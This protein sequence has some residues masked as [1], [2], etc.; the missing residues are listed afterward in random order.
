M[1][2]FLKDGKVRRTLTRTVKESTYLRY[3]R[4]LQP[5]SRLWS[6]ETGTL[7]DFLIVGA[8][9]SGSTFLHDC[10]AAAT[11]A[12]PSPLQKEVHYFD[13]KYYRSLDW[14]ARFFEDVGQKGPEVQTYEASPYYL[15]NP[16]VP[17]RVDA[18]LPDVKILAVLREPVERAVSHY[19][20]MRQVELETREAEDAFRADA[21]RA[22]LERDERYLRNFEDPLYFDFDHIHYGYIRRSMYHTQIERWRAHF[23]PSD[24]RIL[25]SEDLFEDT[26]A[27][28][29]SVA[30]F[31]GLEYTGLEDTNQTNT[32]E[33]RDEIEVGEAAYDIAERALTDVEEK[34]RAVVDPQMII[35]GDRERTTDAHPG[36]PV[37]E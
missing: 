28:L 15:F 33:S 31:L 9:R 34:L 35:T 26:E 13:N 30:D 1:F 7:P 23:G 18:D 32:N 8:Q 11:T 17:G 25:R 22:H 4:L 3:I 16:A 6:R 29:Q 24:I 2:S 19:K 37:H 20:W 12:V 5:E 10:L 36:G 27:V 21:E 14:Y